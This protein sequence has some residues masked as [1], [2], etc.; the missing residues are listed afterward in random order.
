MEQNID[1]LKFSR[2]LKRWADET[3]PQ[4]IDWLFSKF[5]FNDL[6]ALIS[7]VTFYFEFTDPR[8]PYEDVEA[9]LL[10]HMILK[11]EKFRSYTGTLYNVAFTICK[12]RFV[13]M[14]RSQ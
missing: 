5:L 7:N 11:R 13:D 6:K 10:L 4:V 2:N 3:E 8:F 14:L 1:K 9:E 12:M